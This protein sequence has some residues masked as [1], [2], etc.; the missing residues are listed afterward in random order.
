MIAGVDDDGRRL[1]RLLRKALP[2]LPLS[3]IHR[4]LRRGRVLAGGKPGGAADRINAG[5]VI[6]I[7][8][9]RAAGTRPSRPASPDRPPGEE[10]RPPDILREA[11]GLLIVNKPAGIGVHGPSA[12]EETLE[13]LVRSF[14]ADRLPPSLSFK[15]GPLHRLDRNTSGVMVFSS[16][17]EGARRFS[18]LIR[19]G[20]ITKRYLALVEGAAGGPAAVGADSPLNVSANEE[21]WEDYLI[22]D[23][24]LGKSF[25]AEA[26]AGAKR[27]LARVR[28]LAGAG[29]F[30]LIMLEISTGRTHQI[31][32]QA[33]ARGHPLAGDRK[34][35][36]KP[37]IGGFLLHAHTLEFPW[38]GPAG[39]AGEER[40]LVSAPLP[41][42]FRKTISEL[43]AITFKA[44][45][46]PSN[47]EYVL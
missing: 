30:S 21:T 40:I 36:G 31:R 7:L 43:F 25:T 12:G 34:Y 2:D 16:S 23:K 26:G 1:D 35:G 27:A 3:A 44:L 15:P 14:L 9:E 33:A 22:R 45:D 24:S 32:A 37:R 10:A 4:L 13:T 46:F 42:G 18:A 28:P 47:D 17:L 41:E 5:T 39:S 38:P 20:R 11:P 19:E 8:E 6:R 29:G